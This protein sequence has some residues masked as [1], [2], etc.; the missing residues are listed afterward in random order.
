MKDYLNGFKKGIPIC[1]GY[2]S[3]SFTFGIMVVN[4]G[5]PVW[6]ALF[7]SM[8]NLTSSGQF[9]GT[10]LILAGAGYFEITLATFIINIRYMLMSLSLSQKI[11]KNTK[12]RDKLIFSFGITD[13][14]FAV[15]STEENNVNTPYMY[16][17]VTMPYI[18]WSLGTLL[19]AIASNLL[20]DSLSGAMGIALY[21][22]FIA[23][24]IPASKKSRNVLFIIIISVITTCALKY[25][26]ILR[27]ISPGFRIIIAT[28]IGAGVGAYLFPEHSENG[29]EENATN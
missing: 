27:N 9:A 21:G 26:P 19:G 11:D 6:M 4:S 12:T 2:I 24:I 25:L 20:P 23:I 28:L 14:V 3:V 10:N 16:G 17:L 5:L 13:E 1:L 15:A 7:I 22:M 8:T 18:G 29:G